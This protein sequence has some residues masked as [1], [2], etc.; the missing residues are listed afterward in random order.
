[1]TVNIVKVFMTTISL[2][3]QRCRPFAR[4]TKNIHQ[5]LKQMLR[6]CLTLTIFV[7]WSAFHLFSLSYKTQFYCDRIK[8]S[9]RWVAAER[10]TGGSPSLCCHSDVNSLVGSHL[11]V[12]S[13]F[14]K[15]SHIG[16]Y[17]YFVICKGSTN[18]DKS[19][20]V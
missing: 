5:M 11:F 10:E 9:A 2:T 16:V 7:L 4:R 20:L 1:M 6:Y 8:C 15:N 17:V 14:I 19:W 13:G 3:Q 18:R 12:P